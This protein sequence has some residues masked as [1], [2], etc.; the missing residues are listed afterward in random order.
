MT[1]TSN[2]NKE[3][4]SKVDELVSLI[5][6]QK[7]FSEDETKVLAQLELLIEA[8]LFQQDAEENPEEYLLERFQERLYNFER[9]YPSLSSFIRRISN[10]LSNIGV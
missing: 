1:D 6:S 5:E 10:S 4:T 2:S 7:D 3:L 9:E 8:R